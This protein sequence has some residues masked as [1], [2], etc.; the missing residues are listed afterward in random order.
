M[1]T[2]WIDRF[3]E[4]PWGWILTGA[5]SKGLCA[6]H[7]FGSD[8]LRALGDLGDADVRRIMEAYVRRLFPAQEIFWKGN[9]ISK[10]A[11]EALTNY[12]QGAGSHPQVPLDWIGGTVFQRMVWQALCQIPYGTA[13][14]Y[15]DIAR[16]VGCPHGARAVGQACGKNPTAIVVPCHRVVGRNG[17]PGG[18]SGGLSIKKALLHL[19]GIVIDGPS[20]KAPQGPFS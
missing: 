16:S 5:T 14:T 11:R 12:L 8:F 3:L 13:V 10:A 7:V 17:S 1:A 20:T 6:C 4:P 9:D 15:T 19:E 18:Y 2:V